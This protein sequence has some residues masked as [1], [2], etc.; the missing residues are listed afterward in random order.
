MGV[1]VFHQ[2]EAGIQDCDVVIMLRLQNEQVRPAVL[3]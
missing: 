3:L 2:L 1:R